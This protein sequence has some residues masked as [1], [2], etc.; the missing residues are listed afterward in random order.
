MM[1][2][3]ESQDAD[4]MLADLDKSI[5]A[6]YE[7]RSILAKKEIWNLEQEIIAS[8]VQVEP[9]PPI[10]TAVVGENPFFH[11]LQDDHHDVYSFS[12]KPELYG[13]V[14]VSFPS[15]PSQQS[16]AV[17]VIVDKR[18]MEVVYHDHEYVTLD[19]PYISG[20]LAFREIRPLELL[21]HRQVEHRP[22]ITPQA[23]L[24]DGNGIL[25]PRHAGIA[26][27]LGTRLNIPTIGIGKSLSYEGG[28]T[29]ENLDYMMDHFLKKLLEAIQQSPQTLAPHLSRYRG[30]IMKKLSEDPASVD[31]LASPDETYDRKEALKSL[32][33]YG[34]GIGIPLMGQDPRF[35]ILGCALVGQGGQIAA[36]LRSAPVAGTS[37][38]IFVSVGHKVSLHRAVQVTAALSLARIPEPVRQADLYGRDLLRRKTGQ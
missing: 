28:W 29:R 10:D 17:Y 1:D 15:D 33:T 37:K 31:P 2:E 18:T 5:V 8:I 21:V 16:V 26:C 4:E 9:D 38:P 34:N 19:V 12:S 36:S 24:V 11:L 6:N 23:I 30:L 32:A 25:H 7:D 35:P 14:D 22:E 20:Y 13:G 27:F 3:D